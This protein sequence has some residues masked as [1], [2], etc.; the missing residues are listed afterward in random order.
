MDFHFGGRKSISMGTGVDTDGF[1]VETY[2]SGWFPSLRFLV[3]AFRKTL[4]IRF[5]LPIPW[6]S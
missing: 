1:L 4:Y 6:F 3:S 2:Y 5:S